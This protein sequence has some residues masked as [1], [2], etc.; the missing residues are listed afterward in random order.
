MTIE[1]R[2]NSAKEE[3]QKMFANNG[4]TPFQM[5]ITAAYQRASLY[6][7]GQ[8][9]SDI[10]LEWENQ[11][12][13][14]TEKYKDPQTR[15]TFIEHVQELK[16]Y[17]NREFPGRF[18]NGKKDYDN[19]F[20]IAHAQKSLSVCLKHLWIQGK[21]AIPPI[22]P[23][24]RIMLEHVGNRDAW[25]KVNSIEDKNGMRGYDSHLTLMETKAKK[26]GFPS[27]AEWEVVVWY[28]HTSLLTEKKKERGQH[29][30]EKKSTTSKIDKDKADNQTSHKSLTLQVYNNEG[31]SNHSK[32]FQIL[33]SRGK[34]SHTANSVYVEF[35]KIIYPANI[36]TYNRDHYTLSGKKN[37][38]EGLIQANN[39]KPGQAFQCDF[40]DENGVHIYKIVEP[41]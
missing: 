6:A 25:T 5:G 3:F 30:Q 40:R 29:K 39:W 19:E 27:T 20:R 9:N 11:L 17:M 7:P 18:N 12:K 24:D 37:I 15:E 38:K 26:D 35:Q 41:V 10:R 21:C 1:E 31:H 28:E 33:G 4:K 22:C 8:D 32:T 34:R 23:I 36:G 2:I 16:D 13:E 14:I